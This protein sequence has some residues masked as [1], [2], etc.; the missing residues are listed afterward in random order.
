MGYIKNDIHKEILSLK[1][2]KKK[3]N[4]NKLMKVLKSYY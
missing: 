3:I 2:D 4:N 1:N